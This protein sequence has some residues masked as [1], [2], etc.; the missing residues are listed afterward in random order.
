MPL[1]GYIAN[2]DYDWYR[3]LSGQPELDE[4]NFWQPSG[5]RAFKAI[6]ASSPFFFKLKHP[7]NAI[8]GFGIFAR[9]ERSTVS[10]AWDAF[11]VKNGAADLDEMRRL[12]ERHRRPGARS[13]SGDYEIGCIMI[14]SPVFFS[15]EDWIR[16]PS[17]W[18]RNIV[19]GFTYDLTGG[20]GERIWRA[21]SDRM[22][23]EHPG[24]D[25]YGAGHLVRGRLGQGA[26]RL[27]VTEAYGRACAVSTEH[28]LPALEA[29]HIRPYSEGGEH[30][31]TNGVLLR[32]DIHRLFDKGYVTVTPDYRFEISPRLRSDFGNGRSYEGFGGNLIVLPTKTADRPDPE[33]LRWHNESRFLG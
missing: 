15:P 26:F 13:E 17:D 10:L 2:T 18:A 33:L 3:F 23:A 21:C 14:N 7:H 27:T 32:I 28:S 1:R 16:Q 12:I 30:V 8:A 20:E 4:V 31:L 9:Y 24:E 5:G 11:G 29:A 22:M 6:P 19:Q 25:R